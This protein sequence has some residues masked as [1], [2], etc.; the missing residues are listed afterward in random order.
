[1]S[2]T[3]QSSTYPTHLTGGTREDRTP[4]LLLARQ[5][6]SQLSYG[7]KSFYVLL[8]KTQSLNHTYYWIFTLPPLPSSFFCHRE[9]KSELRGATPNFLPQRCSSLLHGSM[10][11]YSRTGLPTRKF[12]R[13]FRNFTFT[14]R[15]PICIIKRSSS[16][17]PTATLTSDFRYSRISPTSR[18]ERIIGFT[19]VVTAATP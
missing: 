18:Q 13:S 2:W 12:H 17:C 11:A 19:S 1:M 10:S 4:D 16:L 7:P 6:L 8:W 5:A 15:N 3:A 9:D 14:K